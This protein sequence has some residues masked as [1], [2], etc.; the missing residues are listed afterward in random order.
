MNLFL[1]AIQT[2]LVTI[3]FSAL[4]AY[5]CCLILSPEDD[6]YEKAK[7]NATIYT[8]ILYPIIAFVTTVFQL[9]I[10]Y[11]GSMDELD[12]MKYLLS[13]TMGT[14]SIRSIITFTAYQLQK[15]PN[16]PT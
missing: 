3:L 2:Y 7:L 16:N 5:L 14:M 1:F 10:M 15:R 11:N 8:R 12:Y 13:G 4:V 6:N 9:Q